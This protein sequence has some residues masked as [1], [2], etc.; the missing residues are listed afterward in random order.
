M[1]RRRI[2][3][4]GKP[5]CPRWKGVDSKSTGGLHRRQMVVLCLVALGVAASRQSWAQEEK[6]PFS[7]EEL[8][9]ILAPIALYQDALLSQVLMAASYPLEVVEAARWS[10]ANPAL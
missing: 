2:H 1:S 10:Q 7:P 3:G 5:M 9:Q 4:T 6:K 8:D